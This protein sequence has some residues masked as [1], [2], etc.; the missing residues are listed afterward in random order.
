MTTTRDDLPGFAELGAVVAPL[1]ERAAELVRGMRGAA[2]VRMKADYDPVTEADTASEALLRRGLKEAFPRF[3]VLGEEGG[4]APGDAAHDACWVVD[5]LDGTLNYDSGLC[6]VAVSVALLRNGN[7]VAGWVLDAIH[8]NMYSAGLGTGAFVDGEPLRPLP[9]RETRA[10]G[11]SSQL[12]LRLAEAGL[13][14]EFLHGFGKLRIVGSQALHL[15]WAAEGRLAAALNWE[16]RLWDDAAAALVLAE[17]GGRYTDLAGREIF[18][19]PSGSGAYGGDKLH[20]VG[21]SPALHARL[22][23]LAGPLLSTILEANP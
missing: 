9:G 14:E 23:E 3:A 16:A 1:M 19:L 15:C 20:S 4:L 21:A 2:A 17:A 10:V 7:P 5:P 6:G 8:G 18:P 13:A 12:M 11:V 22:V